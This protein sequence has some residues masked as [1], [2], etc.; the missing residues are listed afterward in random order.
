MKPLLVL[1]ATFTI[2]LVIMKISGNKMNYQF[3]GK[4]SLST[5]LLFTALGHFIFPNGMAKMLPAFIPYRLFWIYFTGS[6]ECLFAFTL[7]ISRMSNLT[8]WSLLIF[9]LILLPAN[10]YACLIQLNYQTGHLDGKGLNYLWFRIPLQVF[11]MLWIYLSAIL[12]R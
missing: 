6:L 3:A 7:L 10:I 1:T 4:I 8:A 9:F 5:M 11:F 12:E 2:T